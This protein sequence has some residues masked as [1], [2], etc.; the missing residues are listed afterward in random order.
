M[1]LFSFIFLSLSFLGQSCSIVREDDTNVERTREE[2][3]ASPGIRPSLYSSL[4]LQVEKS[5]TGL[6]YSLVQIE[7]LL[8]TK[9]DSTNTVTYLTN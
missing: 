9:R 2:G 3:R 6:F 8:L 4:L 7:L 5:I 1:P